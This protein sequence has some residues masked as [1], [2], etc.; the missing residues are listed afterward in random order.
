[1]SE[2]SYFVVMCD[3]DG[4]VFEQV[5]KKTLLDRLTPE[6]YSTEDN[7]EPQYYGVIEEFLSDVPKTDKHFMQIGSGKM[8]VIKGKIV[9]PTSKEVTVTYEVD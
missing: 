1:M 5:D 2:D 3:V 8:L 4:I 9:Q 6:K 7:K